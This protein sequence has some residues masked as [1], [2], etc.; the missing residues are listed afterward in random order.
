[1]FLLDFFRI[2]E[3]L[4]LTTLS[5]KDVPA[6]CERWKHYRPEPGLDEYMRDII[7]RF[8]SSAL[9]DSTGHLV[10]YVAMQ[11]NGAMAMLFVDPTQRGNG[12]HC[13]C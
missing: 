8:E 5:L 1:M 9:V 13:L 10:A 4:T 11:Y 6:L 12:N 3:G 2:P 7:S